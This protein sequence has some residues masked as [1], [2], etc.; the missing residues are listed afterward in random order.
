MRG[1][2][3]ERTASTVHDPLC[4]RSFAVEDSGA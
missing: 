3:E 2:F 4:V 1:Y